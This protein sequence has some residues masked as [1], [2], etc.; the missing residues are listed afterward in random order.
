MNVQLADFGIIDSELFSFCLEKP[1]TIMHFFWSVK[2]LSVSGKA[3]EIGVPQNYKSTLSCLGFINS[4][5][6]KKT[7][8]IINF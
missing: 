5:V 4:L 8:L 2:L 1:E 6:F 3:L 7:V